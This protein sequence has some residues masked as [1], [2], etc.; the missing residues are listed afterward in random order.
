MNPALVIFIENLPASDGPELPDHCT[1]GGTF[2]LSHG[3]VQPVQQV[4]FPPSGTF[5]QLLTAVRSRVEDLRSDVL[6]VIYH[7]YGTHGKHLLPPGTL[8]PGS[9]HEA[10]RPWAGSRRYLRTPKITAARIAPSEM[11]VVLGP[12]LELDTEQEQFIGNSEFT[13]MAN[14]LARGQYRAPYIIPEVV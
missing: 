9:G 3:M 12:W 14:Q 4:I 11:E 7:R 6:K 10:I 8:L 5:V 2:L 13:T 1:C